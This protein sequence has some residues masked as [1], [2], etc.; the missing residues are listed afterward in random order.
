VVK[1]MEKEEFYILYPE[2]D[3]PLIEKRFYN[4]MNKKIRTVNTGR[5]SEI[6]EEINKRNNLFK[7]SSE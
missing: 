1:A 2:S 4:I 3:K 6:F 5:S 7:L